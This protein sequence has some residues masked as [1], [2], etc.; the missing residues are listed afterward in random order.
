M[1]NFFNT[2]RVRM[3][4]RAQYNRTVHEIRNMPQDVAQ[5]LGIFPGDARRIAHEAVYG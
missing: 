4:K 2:V 1:N 3:E 5:D